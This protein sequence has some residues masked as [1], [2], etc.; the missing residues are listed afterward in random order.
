MM[1][2][3]SGRRA[4]LGRHLPPDSGPH[5]RHGEREGPDHRRILPRPRRL[6]L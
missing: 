3:S 5:V 4:I 2:L 1:A 6:P